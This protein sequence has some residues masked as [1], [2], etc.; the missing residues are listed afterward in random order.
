M[1]HKIPLS[2]RVTVVFILATLLPMGIF[3]YLS[4]KHD[5]EQ[6]R[7]DQQA[8][9]QNDANGL[10]LQL[11]AVARQY[12]ILTRA[13]AADADVVAYAQNRTA[14]HRTDA[15]AAQ[16]ALHDL[17]KLH[18]SIPH[19]R[20]VSIVSEQAVVQLSSLTAPVTLKPTNLSEL[21]KILSART[22]TLLLQQQS[23][24]FT[25]PILSAKQNYLGMMLV[26]VD[27][28][29]MF[30][31]LQQEALNHPDYAV[32]LQ[33]ANGTTLVSI[34]AVDLN[35]VDNHHALHRNSPIQAQASVTH[36]DL[37]I[38]LSKADDLVMQPIKQLLWN[39]GIILLLCLLSSTGATWFI[40]R[41]L[42][43]PIQL[44]INKSQQVQQG[45]YRTPE[46]DGPLGL[47]AARPDDM[48]KF[49]AV[50]NQMVTD[51]HQRAEILESLIAERTAELSSSNQLL[52]QNQQRLNQELQLAHDM[53]QA[54]LPQQFVH[55]L[56]FEV[57]AAMHPAQEMGGDFYDCFELENGH[58]ALLVAD[59]AGKGIAAAFFMA[60]SSTLIKQAATKHT[61]PHRVLNLA[62]KWL[63]QHNP[64][65]LFVTVFYAVFDP[66]TL[67][68]HYANAGHPSAL[69]L[70]HQHQLQTLDS[71]PQL[72]LG[73]WED[74]SYR[75]H[76][77]ALQ[78][79]DCVV[80]Y[81]DGVTEAL[82]PSQQEY[83]EQ[84][85]HALLGIAKKHLHAQDIFQALK[86]DVSLFVESAQA[87]DDITALV[88]KVKAQ[89]QT[90]LQQQRWQ[91]APT[92][93]DIDALNLAIS[94]HL[95]ILLPT[96]SHTIYA[97]CVCLEEILSNLV[98]HGHHPADCVLSITI[99]VY[100]TA[101]RCCIRDN[102]TPF[103]PF[104][105][106]P[107]T[108]LAA[109]ILDKELGGLGLQLLLQLA[110]EWDYHSHDG[111]NTTLFNV[112]FST[113]TRTNT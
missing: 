2:L 70:S 82:S 14:A 47:Q 56:Q 80:L 72:P 8:A 28:T 43:Q 67:T 9:L 20:Q 69:W 104:A 89:P 95:Q 65:N 13:I 77:V 40:S 92:F 54:F 81:S 109:D 76:S 85:L 11:Q 25:A 41:R 71:P 105:I 53:Q 50:Y 27:A 111:H 29:V 37:I 32:K 106:R 18:Q 60:I 66:H 3:G 30:Q 100:N 79:H 112:H 23:L 7:H 102:S 31:I 5:I 78:P 59:V 88:L 46:L 99:S 101:I 61:E 84:R 58:H 91:I 96:Q 52:A 22:E 48:G 4:V 83:G 42:T 24:Y 15:A 36:S 93:S 62:N 1:L 97:V 75:S 108:D 64:L 44:L 90:C 21:K 86:N 55:A 6:I 107:K 17:Q 45:H 74:V 63:C 68:L 73:A 19:A 94:D 113:H 10:T 49:I 110:D 103:N 98:R 38:V 12:Q 26:E 16:Q 35:S 33:H 34:A 51:I 87:H 39:N 57:F